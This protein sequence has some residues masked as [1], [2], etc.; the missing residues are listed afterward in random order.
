LV[1][2]IIAKT[3]AQK[4]QSIVR[5]GILSNLG[6]GAASEASFNQG[7]LLSYTV[8]AF[9]TAIVKGSIVATNMGTNT[10]IRAELF[11]TQ[12]GRLVAVAAVTS[13]GQTEKFEFEMPQ[14][15]NFPVDPQDFNIAAHGNNPAND[16]TAEWQ[17]EIT[18]L[19]N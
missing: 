16:G 8:P 10:V 11:D 6:S 19:P 2:A 5:G 13:V 15:R 14:L 7:G 9:K 3:S 12:A 4:I 1:F 17:A 18:E